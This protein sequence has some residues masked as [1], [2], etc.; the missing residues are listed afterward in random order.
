MLRALQRLL[1]GPDGCRTEARDC[2]A[3]VLKRQRNLE[4]HLFGQS[5]LS[6]EGLCTRSGVG[7]S[8]TFGPTDRPTCGH[9]LQCWASLFLS[10]PQINRSS[11]YAIIAG[12]TIIQASNNMNVLKNGSQAVLLA[13]ESNGPLTLNNP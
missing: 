6:F 9:T 8:N 2:I 11:L 7:S 13:N 3:F 4:S 12:G 10:A 5:K 1:F